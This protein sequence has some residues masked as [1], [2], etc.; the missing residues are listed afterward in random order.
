MNPTSYLL[1][2]LPSASSV[3]CFKQSIYQLWQEWS[4]S[5][6]TLSTLGYTC[7]GTLDL[8]GGCGDKT[9]SVFLSEKWVKGVVCAIIRAKMIRTE[10]VD[11]EMY[12]L[13]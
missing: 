11:M 6:T 4:D 9:G 8:I 3:S 10:E 12:A 13:D 1:L 2:R 7:L 5:L